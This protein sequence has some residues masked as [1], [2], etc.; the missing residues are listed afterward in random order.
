MGKSDNKSD[1]DSGAKA[2]PRCTLCGWS[3]V[4]RMSKGTTPKR[5]TERAN[6]VMTKHLANKH[7]VFEK[8]VSKGKKWI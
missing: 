1:F 4:M 5:V 6:E 8:K 3:V 7:G 2:V